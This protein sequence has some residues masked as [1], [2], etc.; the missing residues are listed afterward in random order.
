MA[1]PGGCFGLVAEKGR[2]RINRRIEKY[3]TWQVVTRAMKKNKEVSK[4]QEVVSR[5]WMGD[6][7]D[8]ITLQHMCGW[9]KR[10]TQTNVYGKSIPGRRNSKIRPWDGN[11]LK[12]LRNSRDGSVAGFPWVFGTWWKIR[13]SQDP[14]HAELSRP[15]SRVLWAALERSRM[16]TRVS[17]P[18]LI[19]RGGTWTG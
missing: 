16:C 5:G 13:T 9:C 3:I 10:G 7:T 18:S 8:Q 1:L 6:L 11:D 19:L 15:R 4:W 2:Q 17:K 14:D 12:R